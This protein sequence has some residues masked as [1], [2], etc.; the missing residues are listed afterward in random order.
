MA[1]EDAPLRHYVV[2]DFEATCDKPK[3]PEPHEIIEFPSVLLDAAGMDT[4]AEFESFVR[5]THHPTLTPFCTELTGIEQSQV[6]AAEAFPEVFKA[7]QAWLESHDLPA[8]PPPGESLSHAFLTCGD[9]DLQTMLPSQLAVTQPPIGFVPHAYR[10]WINIKRPFAA[11][12]GTPVKNGMLGMLK[13]LD[14]ELEGRHHRGIDDCRNI[15]RIAR[16][17]VERGQ[18]LEIDGELPFSRYPPLP[19]VLQFG[20]ERQEVVLKKRSMATLIGLASSTFRR[21]A[22]KIHIG[23]EERVLLKAKSLLDLHTAT[24]LYIS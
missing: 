1:Q 19:L 13:A 15:A 9:W 14:L 18:K 12:N 20:E 5:P 23:E 16:A 24:V 8:S 6:D 10:R 3:A 2:L 22:Q 7:H 11:W 17:L 4:K 21:Q